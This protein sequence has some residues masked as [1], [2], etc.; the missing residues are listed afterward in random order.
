VSL[1]HSD[2]AGFV[3]A[4]GQSTRMGADKALVP[5]AGQPLI[6]HALGILRSAGLEPAIAGAGS[7][8]SA[9]APIIADASPH[10]GPLGGICAAMSSTAAQWAVF[11]SVD[12]PLLPAS[13]VRHL[14]FHAQITGAQVTIASL[15]GFPQTFP[16]VIHRDAQPTLL[17]ELH[18]RRLGCLRAYQ[19]VADLLARPNTVL[20]VELLVQP[21][22][23]SNRD[24]SPAFSPAYSWFSNLNSPQ[25]VARAEAHFAASHRVS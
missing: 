6:A 13:L 10:L 12:L 19:A 9:Y 16:A 14:L 4:G 2:A 23:V 22:Q 21:G 11:I 5:F 18:H 15:N 24:G 1:P 17:M 3:L 8:L 20:P 25:D 7:D